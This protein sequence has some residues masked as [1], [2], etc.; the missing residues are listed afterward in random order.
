MQTVA[1]EYGRP[2]PI[3]IEPLS[4]LKGDD[5]AIIA[6]LFEKAL[7]KNQALILRLVS[8]NAD[9][10]AS[11]FLKMVSKKTGIPLSTLKLNLKILREK[12][13]VSYGRIGDPKPVKLTRVG[14]V[15]LQ[16]LSPEMDDEPIDCSINVLSESD[17]KFV[18]DIRSKILL[19]AYS[20]R[21]GHLPS[22]LSSTYI[23]SAIFKVFRP[24]LVSSENS[25]VLSKGHASLALYAVLSVEGV[26]E[27]NELTY[28]CELGSRLQGHPDKRFIQETLVSTGSLGQGL[29]IGVGIA[30]GKKLKNSGGKVIV[31]LGDGELDEGQIWEAAMS[32]STYRL[33]NLIAIVDRNFYQMNGA[34]EEI[35]CLEPLKEK[36]ISFGWDVVEVDGKR[37]EELI[38][39][40]QE[41]KVYQKR[42]TVIIA[43]TERNGGIECL[44]KKIFYFIPSKEDYDRMVGHNG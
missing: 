34:T 35:K 22:S 29:S 43:L 24:N 41:I 20:S 36:W 9:L 4:S 21:T 16:I 7:N 18:Q 42:P 15:V 26:I 32:A 10:T 11:S 44:D 27:E 13:L 3:S 25:F 1:G 28:F 17:K 19:Q 33:D 38:S 23:I 39:I 8:K 5:R 37:F 14:E 30:L 12:G 6:K 31:L 40:L 2:I